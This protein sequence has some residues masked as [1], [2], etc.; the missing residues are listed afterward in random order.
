MEE[1]TTQRIETPQSEPYG[2]HVDHDSSNPPSLMYSV[3]LCG[4]W[5]PSVINRRLRLWTLTPCL[6]LTS[7]PS[8]E[9]SCHIWWRMQA[10]WST[11]GSR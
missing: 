5:K 10:S 8:P 9:P 2:G 1:R 6:V 3:R 11:Y 4:Y 7:S